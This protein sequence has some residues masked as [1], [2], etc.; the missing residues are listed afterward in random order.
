MNVLQNGRLI[1]FSKGHIVGARLV[2]PSVTATAT[3]LRVSRA[4]ISKVMMAYTNHG[5]TAEMNSGRKPKLSERDRNTLKRIMSKSH[6]TTAAKVTAE[7][8]I[9]CEDPVSTKIFRREL[10]KS[11]LHGRA[12]I[13]KPLFTEKQL[14]KAK[15]K[16]V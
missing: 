16:K 2:G 9:Y 1:R 11:Y 3:L 4:A 10:H 7:L 6:R 12:A 15:K 13:T 8:S 5:K 14:L